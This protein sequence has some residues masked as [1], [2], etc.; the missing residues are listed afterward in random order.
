MTLAVFD[1][2]GRQMV[3]LTDGESEPGSHSVTWSGETSGGDIVG[4]GV[5]FVRLT[6]SSLTSERRFSSLRK[7]VLL[8]R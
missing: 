5:Y 1:I 3:V 6:A 7:M 2:A 4:A 8:N